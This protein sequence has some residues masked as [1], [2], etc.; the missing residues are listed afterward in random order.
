MFIDSAV[1]VLLS[2]VLEAKG[3]F[4]LETEDFSSFFDDMLE[5]SFLLG[6]QKFLNLSKQLVQTNSKM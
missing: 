3:T 6:Y 2:E 5:D 4:E 1:A